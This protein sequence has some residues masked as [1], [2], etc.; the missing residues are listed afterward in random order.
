MDWDGSEIGILVCEE[1]GVVGVEGC[2]FGEGVE[3]FRLDN[4]IL[5]NESIGVF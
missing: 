5:R 1:E 3:F 2:E 4:Y